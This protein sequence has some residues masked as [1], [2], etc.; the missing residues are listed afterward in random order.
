MDDKHFSEIFSEWSEE[1]SSSLF[2]NKSL[3]VALF[4]SDRKLLFANTAMYSLFRGSPAECFLNPTLEKMFSYEANTT[5]VYDGYLTIGDYSSVNTSIFS[6]VYRK[7][8]KLLIIGGM[9]VQQL[10][11]QNESLHHLNQE[12]NNLQ[13]QL[14]K[15]KHALEITLARLNKANREQRELIATKD[16]LF[17]IIAHDLKNPFSV[18]LGMSELLSGN[19][20]DYPPERV[21]DFAENIYKTSSQAYGLL[22]NLL[23]WSRLQTG[24][25]KPVPKSIQPSHVINEVK[26]LCQENAVAKQI[27]LHSAVHCDDHVYVDEE[28]LKTILRNLVTNALKFTHPKGNVK[29]ESFHEDVTVLFQ[30]TDTGFGIDPA[31]LD[32]LFGVDCTLSKKGTANEKGTGLGLLLCKEFVEANNGEIW[33]ESEL[34]KGSTFKFTVPRADS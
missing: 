5:L 1:I 12:I 15:E 33:V 19:V 4:S 13:R 2:E 14:I 11:T 25:L 18:L 28:M 22:E 7:E 26:E 27:E 21:K 16:K 24:K 6:Q 10:V 8:E 29:I 32:E 20:D 30:V 31:H 3:C 34:E 23:E 17:S 9:D